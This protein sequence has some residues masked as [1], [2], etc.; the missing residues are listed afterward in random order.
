M[1]VEDEHGISDQA[2][3]ANKTRQS[4]TTENAVSSTVH[5]PSVCTTLRL[6]YSLTSQKPPSF[7]WDAT[8]DPA[9]S[10][11]TSSSMF[12]PGAAAAT[13]RHDAR[14]RHDRHGRRPDRNPQQRGNHP[15]EQQRREPHAGCRSVDRGP[16]A[17]HVEHAPESAAGA[18]DEQQRCDRGEALLAESQ[19]I[20]R[21][22][23]QA[24]PKT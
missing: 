1:G 4:A 17:G 3:L 18:D 24:R 16:D 7:T 12:V 2:P 14:G 5:V 20:V 21:S 19:Q 22:R 23:P 15:S 8:I 11:T 13:G 6:K 10:A 9:P